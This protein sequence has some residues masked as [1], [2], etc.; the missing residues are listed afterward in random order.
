ME[1]IKHKKKTKWYVMLAAFLLI[2]LVSS[3]ITIAFEPRPTIDYGLKPIITQQLGITS[4]GDI[5][6][7]TTR[8]IGPLTTINLQFFKEKNHLV[9]ANAFRIFW[10]EPQI[11]CASSSP[12]HVC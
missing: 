7:V 4:I 3:L 12:Q 10:F 11:T 1:N 6:S 8:V 5:Q 9:S 2:M